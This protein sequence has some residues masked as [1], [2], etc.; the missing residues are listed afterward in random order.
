MRPTNITHITY[1]GTHP[2]TLRHTLPHWGT[3]TAEHGRQISESP[4]SVYRFFRVWFTAST[5][6]LHAEL[7]LPP[8]IVL[9]S[10]GTNC[11]TLRYQSYEQNL[12]VGTNAKI[13]IRIFVLY[14]RQIF[15]EYD[16]PI[17][18]W[19]IYVYNSVVQTLWLASADKTKKYSKRIRLV[20]AE[21]S[22]IYGGSNSSACSLKALIC[23]Q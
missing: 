23:W 4:T 12:R 8:Q 19:L 6:R 13:W 16:D 1:T 2:P 9:G 10:A 17:L 14:I 20:P 5:F 7:L 18:L 3:P 22:T 11:N 15:A 21:P